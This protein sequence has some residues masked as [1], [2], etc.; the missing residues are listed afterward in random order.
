MGRARAILRPAHAGRLQLRILIVEDE[1]LIARFVARALQS[2]GFTVG[3]AP[4]GTTACERLLAEEWDLV[5]LDLMLPRRSGF[6]VLHELSRT[7]NQVPVLVLSARRS[8]EDKV[9]ALDAGA[10]DYLAKPFALDEL[11]ARARALLRRGR[12]RA[13]EAL[14]QPALGFALDGPSRTLRWDDGETMTLPEREYGLLEYLLRSQ[15]ETVSRERILSAVW[16]YQFDPRSNVVDVYVGRLRRK[17][18]PGVRIE[19]V[20]G[21][22]YRL[23]AG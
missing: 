22:G 12:A 16:E 17:L 8:V 13:S 5:V 7:D 9:A 2:E 6:D 21:G 18:H 3:V 11:L 14:E 19:T 4:D 1:R 10:T 15:G 23:L 20:R